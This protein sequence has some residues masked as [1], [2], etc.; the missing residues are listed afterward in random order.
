VLTTRPLHRLHGYNEAV[1]RGIQACPIQAYNDEEFNAALAT[2]PV[3][4]RRE[5]I[6]QA[7]EPW[8]RIP[9]LLQT[10]ARL[11]EQFGGLDRVTLEMVLWAELLDKINSTD[12]QVRQVL[13]FRGD[14][15][16]AQIL[17]RLAQE[18]LQTHSRDVG[19][20]VLVECFGDH[21][22]GVL[23]ALEEL[24]IAENAERM[25]TTVSRQANLLGLALVIRDRMRLPPTSSVRGQADE[26]RRFL[27]PLA[28]V[29]ERTQ[30]LYGALQLTALWPPA[31]GTNLQRQRA[32]LLLAWATSHN[33]EVSP[34]RLAFWA[35]KDVLAYSNFVEAL[36]EEPLDESDIELVLSP[37][38][39]RWKDDGPTRTALNPVIQRWLSLIWP[40][41]EGILQNEVE[42]EG[43]RLPVAASP[44]QLLLT[45]AA[46]KVISYSPIADLLLPL[47]ISRATLEHSTQTRMVPMTPAQ[48][49]DL[50][51]HRMPLKLWGSNFGALMRFGFTEAV[52]PDLRRLF[53]Q[54]QGDGVVVRGIQQLIAS[55]QPFDLPPELRLQ[56]PQPAFQWK[57][58]PALTLIREGR[59]LFPENKDDFH[60]QE[61]DFS[62]LA[63]RDDIPDLLAEDKVVLVERA[64]NALG[65]GELAMG[66]R[67]RTPADM[68]WEG[69]DAW[70]AKLNPG[71]LLE[72]TS[73][74]RARAFSLHNPLHA[75]SLVETLIHQP[76]TVPTATLLQN[77]R[78]F[79]ERQANPPSREASYVAYRLHNLA[80]MNFGTAEL[81]Q[82]L[83]YSAQSGVLRGAI[84]HH[85]SGGFLRSVTPT[86]L[87]TLARTRMQ[88]QADEAQPTGDLASGHFDFWA[89]LVVASAEPNEAMFDWT[90][91]AI[92]QHRP[93][94]DRLLHWLC[95]LFAFAPDDRLRAGLSDGT[96]RE[97]FNK[98]GC[99]ALWWI[100]RQLDPAWLTGIQVDE[101]LR[102]LPIGE[103]GKVLLGTGDDAGFYQWGS[104]LL[105]RASA[106]VGKPPGDRRYWGEFL[107]DFDRSGHVKARLVTPE[108][109]PGKAPVFAPPVSPSLSSLFD[110]HAKETEEIQQ[111]ASADCS[112]IDKSNAAEMFDFDG[113]NP[114][115][116]WRKRYPDDFSRLATPFLQRCLERPDRAYHL[117][118]LIHAVLCNLLVLEPDAAVAFYQRFMNGGLRVQCRTVHKIPQF[119]AA[120]WNSAECSSN[121][122]RELRHEALRD[123]SNEQSIMELMIS[124]NA[125]GGIAEAEAIAQEFAAGAAARERAI[126]VSALA[127]IG[128]QSALDRLDAI[129]A[130][131]PALWLRRHAEWASEVNRQ[132]QAAARFYNR[133][134]HEDDAARVST[135]LPQL[136]AAL[137]PLARCWRR[138]MEIDVLAQRRLPAK[139]CAFLTLFWKSWENTER[140][141]IEIAGRNLGEWR[142]GEEIRRLNAP[143]PHPF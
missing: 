103:V 10:C 39:E 32:A 13:G 115:A 100:C 59:H 19:Q 122:H 104:E 143:R 89:R 60:V 52:L 28:E 29:D 48:G 86:E 62:C 91:A 71:R 40:D 127:W 25:R 80:F 129:H 125:N 2:L 111:L 46:L 4:L 105:N 63:V 83:E 106:M 27:E 61:H 98:D 77:A 90:L 82:W 43:H 54:H 94:G 132:N 110:D 36:F 11:R 134:L 72:L 74:Y 42:R 123:A 21:L 23:T 85:P 137:T 133:I 35:Q 121:R 124:A 128:S 44:H 49:A 102:A 3:P 57:G 7:L 66:E 135:M 142:H 65:S 79:W 75:L 69:A 141:K 126:G 6:P 41:A 76:Q 109:R 118:T 107:L 34:S 12:P 101:L 81:I 131:D 84:S 88:E 1:W 116:H 119:M 22:Q 78:E 92:R 108:P 114:L 55:L 45:L 51:A 16:A 96:L 117:G 120:L 56:Q 93:T 14:E 87:S 64:E 140:N 130:Q 26:F 33:A 38:A 18:F 15:A 73:A 113:L 20:R 68:V 9:R 37:L 47:A 50:K 17:S 53:D 70:L 8:A 31:D 95:L 139:V 138:L 58:V 99:N 24:R 112:D 30:A 136:E 5:D 67:A 97:F